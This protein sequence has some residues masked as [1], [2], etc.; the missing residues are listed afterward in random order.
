MNI[1]ITGA[2]SGIGLALMRELLSKGH[3]VIGCSRKSNQY[4][5]TDDEFKKI[6]KWDVRHD[7][8]IGNDLFKNHTYDAV[9]HSAAINHL[10]W[11]VDSDQEKMNEVISTNVMGT[12]NLVRLVSKYR[13]TKRLIILSSVA[14]T[15]P[16][17]CS[18]AYNASKAAVD[19][20]V[21]QASRE[22]GQTLGIVGVRPG[23]IEHTEMASYAKRRCHDL[24]H[25]N[26]DA[27]DRYQLQYT[28][29]GRYPKMEELIQTLVW[30]I[31]EAPLLAMGGSCVTVGCGQG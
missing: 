8:A 10:N 4:G 2:S 25:M 26:A 14:S 7:C 5:C 23:Y 3:H 19:M 1:L 27:F 30:L 11:I 6:K 29:T 28:N 22:Q 16:M 9:V 13:S 24:R 15:Q 17:R 31:K 18:M 12:M 21:K 20:I